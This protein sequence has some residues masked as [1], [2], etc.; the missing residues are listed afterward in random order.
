[1]SFFQGLSESIISFF[2][3]IPFSFRHFAL[4]FIYPFLLFLFIL[5]SLSTLN[6]FLYDYLINQI[7]NLTSSIQEGI[8]HTILSFAIRS[9]I[10][11]MIKLI[12]FLIIYFL[13]AYIVLVLMS[14][15]LSYISE[16]TELIISNK[17]YNFDFNIWIKQIIRGILLSLRNLFL[18]L[19]ITLLFSVIFIIPIFGL[20]LSPFLSIILVLINAYFLGFSFLDYSLE[21]KNY[22]IQQSIQTV[23]K[24]KGLAIGYGLIFYLIMLIPVAGQFITPFIAIILTIAA[25]F[26]VEKISIYD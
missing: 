20:I 21:R 10:F 16:K 18:Q 25:T 3:A 24:N 7:N 23:R 2:K 9:I 14:P 6:M 1:M 12:L 26:S 22:S 17:T 8:L 5:I 19:I 4:S 11:I 15:I 13:S